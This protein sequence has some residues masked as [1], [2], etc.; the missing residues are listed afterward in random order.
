MLL[1]DDR[2]FVEPYNYGNSGNANAN[3]LEERILGSEMTLFEFRDKICEP[4]RHNAPAS[5]RALP[6]QLLQDHFEFAFKQAHPVDLGFSP[7]I[8]LK[9]KVAGAI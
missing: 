7:D 8:K 6:F 4:F 2:L 1:C 9:T 5:N 3:E